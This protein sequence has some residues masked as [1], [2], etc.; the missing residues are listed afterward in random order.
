MED[1]Q[2]GQGDLNQI[3]QDRTGRR[4][5]EQGDDSAVRQQQAGGKNDGRAGSGT[6]R[7]YQYTNPSLSIADPLLA[8]TCPR[9]S[10]N[11]YYPARGLWGFCRFHPGFAGP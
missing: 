10:G 7:H 6:T 9:Y 4:G 1:C 5:S 11:E 8:F 3:R 2:C